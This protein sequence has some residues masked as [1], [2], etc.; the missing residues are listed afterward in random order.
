MPYIYNI[1]LLM[2]NNVR[3]VGELI[4]SKTLVTNLNRFLFGDEVCLHIIKTFTLFL[5]ENIT[6]KYYKDQ[7]F[8][9]V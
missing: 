6:H 5:K 8:D 9:T 2:L 7:L 3:K 1:L 4:I